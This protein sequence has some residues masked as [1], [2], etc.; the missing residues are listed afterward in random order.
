MATDAEFRTPILLPGNPTSALHAA[1]KQYVDN[2]AGSSMP[3]GSVTAFA[4]SSAPTGWLL[5]AGQAVSRTTY[6]AL[7]AAIGTTYGSGDGSTTFNLPDLRGR[8]VAGLDNM[9]GTDANRLSWQ[10]VLGTVG[11]SSTTVDSG[12]QQHTLSAAESGVPA[13]SHGVTDPGHNHNMPEKNAGTNIVSPYMTYA[14]A[15]TVKNSWYSTYSSTTGITIQN[16][17]AAAASAAHNNMQPTMLLN[18]IISVGIGSGVSKPVGCVV[19]SGASLSLPT[20]WT[21]ITWTNTSF[22]DAGVTGGPSVYRL[23]PGTWDIQYDIASDLGA[24]GGAYFELLW[25][26]IGGSWN[27]WYE[28]KS[29]IHNVTGYA[30][31]GVIRNKAMLRRTWTADFEIAVQGYAYNTTRTVSERELIMWKLA[32]P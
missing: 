9:G 4:G 18:Y 13:H 28:G 8:T 7:F 21:T 32:G 12:E 3:A 1:T 2:A 14:W 22:N 29:S 23:T 31:C 15:D 27:V 11:V 5:C 6:A 16:N 19:Y 25:R 26:D 10:N 30:G 17:T 24:A 20:T